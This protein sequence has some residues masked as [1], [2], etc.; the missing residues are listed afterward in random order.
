MSARPV[1][2][3]VMDD[4]EFDDPPEGPH[5]FETD[6]Q[7]VVLTNLELV[8]EGIAKAHEAEVAEFDPSDNSINQQPYIDW[9]DSKY[10]G[11]RRA[12]INLALVGVVTR[13]HHWLIYLANRTREKKNPLFDRSALEELIHLKTM[14]K[15]TRI[16]PQIFIKWV[17]V[18]DSIIHADSKATW[19]HGKRTRKLLHKFVHKDDLN[20]SE[21]D[22]KEAFGNMLQAIG[23]FEHQVELWERAK[24]GPP[25]VFKSPQA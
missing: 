23:L 20:F 1:E 15:R 25:I 6:V 18:R 4:Y 7:N 21:S 11:L 16:K 2:E 22:L 19:R 24:Y 8:L 3:R 17:D 13:F 12:A 5:E 9:I 14:F 10:D